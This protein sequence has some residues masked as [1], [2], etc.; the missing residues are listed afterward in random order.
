MD[1][2]PIGTA[3]KDEAMVIVY[4]SEQDDPCPACNGVWFGCVALPRYQHDREIL[5]TGLGRDGE[6]YGW[7]PTHWMP[8]PDPPPI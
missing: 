8:L 4:V 6:R 3:P 7:Y 2:Q 1:W 5:V